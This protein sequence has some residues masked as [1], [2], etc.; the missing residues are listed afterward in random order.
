MKGEKKMKKQL[1]LFLSVMLVLTMLSGVTVSYAAEPTIS[2][3]SIPENGLVN[4]NDLSD[5]TVSVSS[6]ATPEL[7]ELF[8][9]GNSLGTKTAEPFSFNVPSDVLG[10][11][12]ALAKVKIGSD[13]YIETEKDFTVFEY[14]DGSINNCTYEFLKEEDTNKSS[15]DNR[16]DGSTQW[17]FAGGNRSTEYYQIG[18]QDDGRAQSGQ[19]KCLI[20]A[21]V[22]GVYSSPSEVLYTRFRMPSSSTSASSYFRFETDFYMAAYSDGTE[23]NGFKFG[24]EATING[25]RRAVNFATADKNGLVVNGTTYPLSK[26]TWHRLIFEY[27]YATRVVSAWIGDTQIVDKEVISAN[28]VG[29]GFYWVTLAPT[30]NGGEYRLDN[31]KLYAIIQSPLAKGV[32]NGS[33]VAAELTY[34]DS[35][36]QLVFNR[37]ITAGGIDETKISLENEIGVIT[38]ATFELSAEGN[39]IV[40]PRNGFEPSNYYSLVIPRGTKFAGTGALPKPLSVKFKTTASPLD[41]SSGKIRTAGTKA[42]LETELV[43]TS[44]ETK[45]LIAYISVY[46]NGVFQKLVKTDDVVLTNGNTIKVT[47]PDFVPESGAELKAFVTDN[48]GAP[49]SNKIY[50]LNIE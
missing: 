44:G 34:T 6:D 40:T 10:S 50:T 43:N 9:D 49:I 18:T 21:P 41:M 23:P 1:S 22:T 48:T 45:T 46:K 20:I 39:L 11:H 7:V 2:F 47:T 31:S 29:T 3:D 5:F 37:G 26:N 33:D 16:P 36:A 13:D 24:A 30:K 15:F 8:V 28:G 32:L 35:S 14:V 25:S 42:F 12:T 38:D 27:D 17:V 19:G 4:V